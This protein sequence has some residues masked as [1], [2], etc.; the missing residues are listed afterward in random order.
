M[1]RRLARY[2]IRPVVMAGLLFAAYWIGRNDQRNADHAKLAAVDA[3]APALERMVAAYEAVDSALWVALDEPDYSDP[4]ELTP[5]RL[6]YVL[7]AEL[8]SNGGTR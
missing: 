7:R 3:L 8:A 4:L 6:E 2:A 5:A 1:N